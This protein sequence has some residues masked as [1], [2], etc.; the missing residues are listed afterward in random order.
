MQKNQNFVRRFLS[1]RGGASVVTA[2]VG[3]VVLMV[4]FSILNP[5][6]L[7]WNSIMTLLRSIV[8]FLLVGIGQGYVCIT[9][10]I[11]LSIGSV[12]GMS[13]MMSATMMCNG[14]HPIVAAIVTL[15]AGLVVGVING[16]LVGKFK[17]PPFIAT[18]GTMTIARGMAQLVNGNYNTDNIG[19][20]G[21]AQIFKNIFY[22]GKTLGL[23]NG[24]WLALIIWAI[25]YF[26][27][28]YTRSGRHIYAIGSNVDAARLSG[29]DVFMTTCKVYIIS[30]FCASLTGLVTMAQSGMGDMSAGMSYE[31]YG[32]AA[33]VIGGISTLG[34]SGLLQGVIAGAGVWAIL[35]SGLTFAGVPVAL[36]N[37]IIGLIVVAAVMF[38]VLR[39]TSTKTKK[40]KS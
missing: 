22:Y 13:A 39:R 15:L 18:L 35:Q 11:D 32:V 9:G 4:A 33:A 2:Y 20:E 25:F 8:P 3:V 34:G 31:M 19:S 30:A 23:F 12:V 17:L 7:K 1:K 40:T 24:V 21:A 5:N 29:V 37:I 36:R 6:F 26:L 16:I 14:V 28:S 10:N 27:L 38:D